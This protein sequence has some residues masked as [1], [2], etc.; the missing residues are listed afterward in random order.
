MFPI[1]TIVAGLLTAA[2]LVIAR[3]PGS[4]ELVHRILPYQGLLGVGAMLLG[5]V[6][7]VL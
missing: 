5:S 6:S 2:P 1:L 4:R 7:F 3:K